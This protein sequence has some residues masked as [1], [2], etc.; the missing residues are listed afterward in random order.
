VKETST[1]FL[2]I[3]TTGSPFTGGLIVAGWALDDGPVHSDIK[4]WS[5]ELLD[6][7]RDRKVTKVCHSDYDLKWPTLNMGLSV[8]G[9]FINTMVMAWCMNETTPLDLEW[10]VGHYCGLVKEKHIFIRGGKLVFKHTTDDPRQEMLDYNVNDVEVLR[11][12]Y[13]TL[14]ALMENDDRWDFFIEEQLPYS[15]VILDMECRG[16]PINGE[17]NR[18]L[19]QQLTTEADAE[20]AW[21]YEKGK[22]PPTFNI[23]S[24]QQI[25]KFLFSRDFS[26]KGRI[27]I[28]AED[29]T[30]Y[31]EKVGRLWKTGYWLATGLG[32]EV[33]AWTK[34]DKE[35]TPPKPSTSAPDLLYTQGSNE[36]VQRLVSKYRKTV[37]L[38]EFL[39]RFDELAVDGRLYSSYKQ[40]GTVTGRLSS[41][42]PNLQNVPKRG[43]R[44]KLIRSLFEGNFVIGDYDQLE[45]RIMAHFSGDPR[46]VE[47]FAQGKDPHLMTAKSIFGKQADE[48][49]RE[50]GKTVNY[51]IGYGAHAKKL[52]Q[53]IS[54]MGYPTSQDTAKGY[55]EATQDFYRVWFDYRNWL[56]EEAKR[57]GY[58]ETI[59]GWRRR[60]FAQFEDVA[61]WKKT[62][63]G[64]RQAVNAKIQ[65]SAA[66]IVRRTM[67]ARPSGIVLQV[68]DEIGWENCQYALSDLQYVGE[69]GH[70]YK[71][72]VPL[73]FVPHAVS[74]WGQK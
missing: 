20:R 19:L 13:Y 46:M 9:K 47:I 5:P 22:L 55:L 29:S 1:L 30:F 34:P 24:D 36:W 48:D 53:T 35:T 44:G 38:V 50:I 66:D 2:D 43:E 28:D 58:V 40:T 57:L 64:E 39:G 11:S 33:K 12:L 8:A 73:V 14:Q 71:L 60:L 16:L 25:A 10:V 6:L 18:A 41:A 45:M 74:D 70:G 17:K 72:D 26:I 7:M 52:A 32:L 49:Q 62:S 56:I 3:E 21:L 37:T 23:D 63:Y 67:V 61:D 31:T 42:E 51:G 59:G 27:P 4:D 68:H 69:I 15:K 54:L 65:G